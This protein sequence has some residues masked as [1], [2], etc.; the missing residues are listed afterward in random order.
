MPHDE[1]RLDD[2]I[3]YL[4]NR[5]SRS[6]RQRLNAVLSD[7]GFSITGEEW[8]ILVHLWNQDGQPQQQ[9]ADTLDKDK[10]TLSRLLSSLERQNLVV[11][12]PDQADRRR[13]L[14]YLTPG[15]QALEDEV[16]P[17]ALRVLR[18]AQSGISANHLATCKAVL[19]QIHDNLSGTRDGA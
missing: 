5:A 6:I 12:I 13:R 18:E 16:I 9:I 7:E 11:R 2:S 8:A 15:G 17:V 19:R 4:I 10:T 3:G 14:I 1:Y